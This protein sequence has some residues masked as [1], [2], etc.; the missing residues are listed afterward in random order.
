VYA[1]REQAPQANYSAPPPPVQYANPT[2]PVRPLGVQCPKCKKENM[3]S[4]VY[5]GGCGISLTGMGGI[6]GSPKCY[7]KL[8]PLGGGT[9]FCLDRDK[10]LIGRRSEAEGNF[11]E[12]D[13]TMQ[14]VNSSVSRKHA[15]MVKDEVQVFV[16]DMGSSN[17]TFV[18]DNKV[19][20]G[21]QNPVK[22]GDTIRI[23]TLSFVLRITK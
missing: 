21:V 20:E 10:M 3:I 12:I 8:V 11:P 4:A 22:D 1:P 15:Q 23:G 19:P 16:E 18:N 7:G 5:C 13:L 2:I 9:E 14:D 6:A 17:G